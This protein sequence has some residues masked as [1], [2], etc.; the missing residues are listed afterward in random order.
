MIKFKKIEMI[1]IFYK[2]KF[3]AF[4]HLQTVKYH[5]K[6]LKKIKIYKKK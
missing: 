6:S 1:Q 3:I 4:Y 2:K 5:Q